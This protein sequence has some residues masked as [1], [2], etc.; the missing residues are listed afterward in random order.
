MVPSVRPLYHRNGNAVGVIGFLCHLVWC[1]HG[2]GRYAA[3]H[4]N[5]V[6]ATI[7]CAFL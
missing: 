3:N 2:I 4:K 7:A 6:Y 1:W 5:Y